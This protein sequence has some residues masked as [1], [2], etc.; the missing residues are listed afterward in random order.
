[1]RVLLQKGNTMG[2]EK[3]NTSFH[4]G[5]I[6]DGNGRYATRK[7][8]P[9]I[10]GHEKGARAFE[11]IV[12]A[13]PELGITQLSAYVFSTENWGRPESEVRFIL[14]TFLKYLKKLRKKAVEKQVRVQIIGNRHDVR[15]SRELRHAMSVI[16]EST[17]HC[18]RLCV[19]LAFNYGGEADIH[20]AALLLAAYAQEHPDR[21]TEEMVRDMF[22][23]SLH[24]ALVSD[25][26][27]L[28]RTGGEKRLSNFF[29]FQ[30]RYTELSFLDVC[31]PAFTVE[32]LALEIAAFKKKHRTFGKV[33]ELQ[34]AE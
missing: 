2:Q 14:E 22:L 10:R 13:A 29:P 27:L 9:R 8:L 34:A 23:P 33:A 15:I 7:G 21:S 19:N 1:M 11:A 3:Y 6:M 25:M 26:D 32:H 16:E 31:W 5:F 12:E 24:S 30:T 17:K 4:V 18:G 28:I 20:H